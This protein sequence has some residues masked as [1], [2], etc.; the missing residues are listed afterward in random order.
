M[1]VRG[2][3]V[4]GSAFRGRGH[5]V[6]EEDA[7]FAGSGFLRL[8]H[9][10]RTV[11]LQDSVDLRRLSFDHLIRK[12][13]VFASEAY[14]TFATE[15]AAASEGRARGPAAKEGPARPI[16]QNHHDAPGLEGT[17]GLARQ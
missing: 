10:L 17:K 13:D 7:D 6:V 9:V 12:A 3:G 1:G 5:P 2:A 4:G 14:Q 16:R 8:L 11:V 15:V